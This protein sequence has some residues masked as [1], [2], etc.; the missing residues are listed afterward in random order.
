M[1]LDER[2]SKQPFVKT[3]FSHSY[4]ALT[5]NCV[6]KGKSFVVGDEPP[7][8]RRCAERSLSVKSLS[9]CRALSTKCR[10]A[11]AV[12]FPNHINPSLSLIG[13]S[14]F[15]CIYERRVLLGLHIR[16]FLKRTHTFECVRQ[17]PCDVKGSAFCMRV[18]PMRKSGFRFSTRWVKS[19]ATSYTRRGRVKAMVQPNCLTNAL[20]AFFWEPFVELAFTHNVRTQRGW[21][22]SQ[23]A[24]VSLDKSKNHCLSGA[25][26]SIYD[27]RIWYSYNIWA[28]RKSE[29]FGKTQPLGYFWKKN[30]AFRFRHI[31]STLTFWLVAFIFEK[32]EE[33]RAVLPFFSKVPNGNVSVLKWR[34]ITRNFVIVGRYLSSEPSIWGTL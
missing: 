28:I 27:I 13:G 23:R 19:L 34:L 8:I 6:G 9:V 18:R 24:V 21:S 32:G 15:D 26:T 2:I 4:F 12:I 17:P 25:T 31:S 11:A 10:D 30:T 1:V 3:I 33:R 7:K 5:H 22:L 14:V 20:C 29:T 16:P